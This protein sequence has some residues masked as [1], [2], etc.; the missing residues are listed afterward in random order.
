MSFQTEEYVQLIE[1]QC[2]AIMMSSSIKDKIV[3]LCEGDIPAS[4]RRSPGA[5][6]QLQKMPDANFYRACIPD[7]WTEKRP[8]FFPCGGRG[9][10]LD[11]YFKLLELHHVP[12]G[13]SYL[14]PEKLF[15]IVDLD[16]QVQPTREDYRFPNTEAIFESLYQGTKVNQQE[17]SQHRIWVTGLI[18]K[19]A[20]FLIPELQSMFDD[21][22]I[23]LIFNN[24]PL[25]LEEVY[26]ALGKDINS[27]ANL[28]KDK[29]NLM[30]ACKRISYCTRLD[31]SSI[32]H[33]KSSWLTQFQSAT[34]KEQ[35]DELIYALLMI[36]QVK[37]YWEGKK[38]KEGE[39]LIPPKIFPK[40]S[41][42]NPPLKR[43]Q[44]EL[45]LEIGSFYSKEGEKLETEHH[46]PI[47]FKTLYQ[48]V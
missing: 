7:W 47:F 24:Q 43:L 27:D 9:D 23:P 13:D 5:Y 21:Y 14:N 46:I 15:A 1:Q 18:Y 28:K 38:G 25:Q 17:A 48:F 37:Q 41:P 3:V 20:Y 29:K 40:P 26:L 42:F 31:C 35:K 8:E 34:N 39:E 12:N 19:E 16:L 22:R 32:D 36:K 44:E 11:T 30:T 4:G 6:R 10:V 2:Q 33:L 45:T